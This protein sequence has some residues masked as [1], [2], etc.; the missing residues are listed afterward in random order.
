MAFDWDGSA[1]ADLSGPGKNGGAQDW[2]PGAHSGGRGETLLSGEGSA[3]LNSRRQRSL[4]TERVPG[5]SVN[6]LPRLP[7]LTPP[8]SE[9]KGCR[10]QPL[11]DVTKGCPALKRS[12][13]AVAL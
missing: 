7:Q 3:A 1:S 12:S 9:W 13:P 4:A 11:C 2:T 5:L 10:N 6:S 8:F